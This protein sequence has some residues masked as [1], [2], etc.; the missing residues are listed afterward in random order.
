MIGI[1]Y[2]AKIFKIFVLGFVLVL[3]LSSV[4]ITAGYRFKEDFNDGD[5]TKWSISRITNEPGNEFNPD[6][7]NDGRYIVMESNRDGGNYNIWRTDSKGKNFVKLTNMPSSPIDGISRHAWNPVFH[8]NGKY[9]YYMDNSPT[10]SDFHWFCRTLTDGT[11]G[12][13]QILLIPGGDGGGRLSFSQDGSQFVYHHRGYN[14]AGVRYARHDIKICDSKGSDV[15]DT[16]GY[17]LRHIKTIFGSHL[18]S[19]YRDDKIRG[20]VAWS[21]DGTTIYF[22]K[23]DDEGL[24]SLYSIGINGK[25]P[26]RLTGHSLG[27]CNQPAISPDGTKVVFQCK[28]SPESDYELCLMSSDGSNIKKLTNNDFEDINPTWSCDG[29]TI[30]YSSNADGDYDLYT[31]YP[32]T[33]SAKAAIEEAKTKISEAN[34]RESNLTQAELLLEEAEQALENG[35]YDK[36]IELA[37]QAK[38][39]AEMSMMAHNILTATVIAVV[40][41]IVVSVVRILRKR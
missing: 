41:F 33:I 18:K 10:G 19:I 21:P 17:N 9:V 40:I 22:S 32:L 11:G 2:S 28:E 3:T 37:R 30:I 1:G 31:I 34:S 26:V 36:A 25:C 12:R 15:K 4:G 7:S 6:Q 16:S 23:L 35:D 20:D 27:D 14:E 38:K 5:Y 39:K 13:E 29:N 24:L 8:P